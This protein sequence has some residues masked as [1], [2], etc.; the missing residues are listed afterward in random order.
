MTMFFGV[1]SDLIDTL[2]IASDPV[3]IITDAAMPYVI[4]IVAFIALYYVGKRTAIPLLSR[5][6]Q[7][8]DIDE[9]ARRPLLKASRFVVMFAAVAIAFGVA[10]FGNFLTALAAVAA[11]A[12]LAV[13]FAMQN[14]I[15]NFVSGL[16]IFIE[17]PFRINDWVEWDGNS[18]IVQ[19]ISL[20]VT[21]VKTFDNELL[22]VPNSE[23]TDGVIKNPVAN[24]KLRLRVLFGIGYDEDIEQATEIIIEEAKAH[25]DIMND[26]KPSVRVTELGDSHV[27]LQSRIWIESPNRA[28]FVKT[29]SEYVQSVKERFDAEGI[30]IPYPHRELVGSITVD[31]QASRVETSD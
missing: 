4:F 29:K 21:R 25:P 27:G 30:N 11:A 28:D 18:G 6:L 15:R 7:K 23:L 20:R 16:F 9:H 31:E 14:V 3:V 24:E 5:A 12:T 19:D 26:P 13:G 1:I 2:G 10:G 17:R 22:T 8:R